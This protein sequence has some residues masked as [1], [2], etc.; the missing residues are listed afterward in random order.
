MH[1]HAQTVTRVEQ[2]P[3]QRRVLLVEIINVPHFACSGTYA[4]YDF[5]EAAL[6]PVLPP[7]QVD[8]KSNC[9]H[10]TDG[11]DDAEHARTEPRLPTGAC[12]YC[13]E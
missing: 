12:K 8:D 10:E 3:D 6:H 1:G 2:L 7:P 4:T 5:A 13:A 9:Q 11:R